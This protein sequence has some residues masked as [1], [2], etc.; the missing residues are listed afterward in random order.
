M[1]QEVSWPPPES[2]AGKI[3]P[4]LNEKVHMGRSQRQKMDLELKNFQGSTAH[5]F[6]FPGCFAARQDE[7]RGKVEEYTGDKQSDGE[8]K[9]NNE[10][11]LGYNIPPG[12]TR[13][14][15]IC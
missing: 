7:S 11:P 15:M 3:L 8:T 1:P 4:N 13:T 5:Y 12:T 9:A 2:Q 6:S 10:R 14:K